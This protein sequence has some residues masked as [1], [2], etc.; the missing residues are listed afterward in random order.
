MITNLRHALAS[1]LVRVRNWLR[2]L[3]RRRQLYTQKEIEALGFNRDNQCAH[4]GGWHQIAC[5]RVRRMRF[6][7]GSTTPVE[8]EF[9]DH[10]QWPTDAVIWPWQIAELIKEEPQQ[11]AV[12]QGGKS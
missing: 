5:P 6:A 1:F 9:F 3:L 12:M 7:E 8:V 4:C 11:L 10:G 2:R